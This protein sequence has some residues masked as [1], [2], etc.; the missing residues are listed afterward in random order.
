[1]VTFNNFTVD[2]THIEPLYAFGVRYDKGVGKTLGGEIDTVFSENLHRHLLSTVDFNMFDAISSLPITANKFN[3]KDALPNRPTKLRGTRPEHIL[4][5]SEWTI[6]NTGIESTESG[7][8]LC[9]GEFGHET[10]K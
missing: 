1:M 4:C 9:W 3:L 2:R 6:I 5:I 10:N 8:Y 7:H